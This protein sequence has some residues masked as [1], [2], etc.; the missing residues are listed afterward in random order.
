[1]LRVSQGGLSNPHND[2]LRP[3]LLGPP[4]TYGDMEAW[5]GSV[6]GYLPGGEGSGQDSL[7][8]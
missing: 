3:V 8:V 5:G 1:M 4:A 7:W 2:L 6:T